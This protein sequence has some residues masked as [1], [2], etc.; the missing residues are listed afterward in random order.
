MC[1]SPSLLCQTSTAGKHPRCC[2]A[3]L[4]QLWVSTWQQKLIQTS[5]FMPEKQDYLICSKG[6]TRSWFYSQ[7][8]FV[9]L[10]TCSPITAVKKWVLEDMALF[11]DKL[12]EW[13]WS[14]EKNWKMFPFSISSLLSLEHLVFWVLLPWGSNN[15]EQQLASIF[16]SQIQ[17]P[18]KL[19][20]ILTFV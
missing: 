16:W 8:Q 20:K 5:L 10:G 9:T 12:H 15:K 14:S 4:H 13:V 17:G 1:P 2:H 19:K 11:L 6:R 7:I 18:L 3:L